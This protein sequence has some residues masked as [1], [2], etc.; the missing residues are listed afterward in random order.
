MHCNL[1][2]PDAA[3]VILRFKYIRLPYQ[4]WSRTT[5]HFPTYNVSARQRT[6]FYNQVYHRFGRTVYSILSLSILPTLPNFYRGS[7]SVKFGLDLRH[8][9]FLSH[10]HFE[11]KQCMDTEVSYLM[12]RWW[13]YLLP[14][15]V[16][17]GPSHLRSKFES[18]L[19]AK[20][21]WIV[22]NSAG[23]CSISLKFGKAFQHDIISTATFKVKGSK[24]K[25]TAW[26]RISS[27]KRCKSGSDRLTDFKLDENYP[28][29]ARNTWQMFKV[30]RSNT[31]IAITPPQIALLSSN[32]IESY[33]GTTS[34]LQMFKVKG[35]GHAVT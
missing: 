32:L 17:F 28:R 33:H 11:T 19:L 35:Q 13:S 15:L 14:N 8:H 7:K 1:K 21:C 5:Y 20:K 23:N 10:P 24:V 12:Q 25:V 30:I 34:I 31:E 2:P 3:P 18:Q 6:E 16:Q 26:Q 4:G 9:S 27:E 29:V 22:N